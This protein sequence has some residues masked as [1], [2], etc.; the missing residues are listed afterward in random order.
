MA[1]TIREILDGEVP[2]FAPQWIVEFSWDCDEPNLTPYE[3]A[4]RACM[5]LMM[6][7]GNFCV[8]H[9]RSG[10][11]WQVNLKHKKVVEVGR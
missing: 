3:A 11:V 7:G 8:T 4:E 10:L 1:K 2:D 6:S 5:A 9:V